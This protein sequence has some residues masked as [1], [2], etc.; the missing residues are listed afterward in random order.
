VVFPAAPSASVFS[1]DWYEIALCGEEETDAIIK[2]RAL[3]KD[4]ESQ[5]KAAPQ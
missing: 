2:R 5:E 1:P 4:K 3:N